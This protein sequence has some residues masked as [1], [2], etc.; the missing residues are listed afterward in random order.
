LFPPPG[1]QTFLTIENMKTSFITKAEG[2]ISRAMAHLSHQGRDDYGAGL[3][4]MASMSRGAGRNPLA[5]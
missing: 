5:A 4:Q 2:Q 3:A 1:F